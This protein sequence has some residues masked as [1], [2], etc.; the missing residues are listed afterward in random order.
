MARVAVE[1]SGTFL[2]LHA[3]GGC[4]RFHAIWL[5]D[6]ARDPQTRS[7]GNGQRLIAL[8][9]INP[10]IRIAGAEINGQTLQVTFAPEAKTI[11][12]DL[13]WL[14]AHAYDRAEDH[15]TGWTE[16]RIDT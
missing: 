4:H 10:A 12:Y 6:N 5:R 15:A 16:A 7:P 2:S 8:R 13:A 9:E 14:I 11:A 3:D 1:P